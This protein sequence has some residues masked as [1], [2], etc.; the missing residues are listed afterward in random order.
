MRF[1]ELPSR[2]RVSRRV[3]L[4]FGHRRAHWVETANDLC[5]AL[6]RVTALRF[7]ARG[8]AWTGAGHGAVAV[9]SPADGVVTFTEAGTW[10]SDRGHEL[11]FSNVF[12]WSAVG[13]RL[14]RLE[15]LR[16]GPKH[17][18]H[19]FDLAPVAEGW[20]SVRPHL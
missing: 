7:E 19:L 14:V 17:P 3:G 2:A 9:S 5:D 20:R 18:V 10:R 8:L 11:R 1:V 15:H 6:R 12:R 4:W 13:T 16:F